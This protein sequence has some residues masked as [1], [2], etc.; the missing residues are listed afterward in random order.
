MWELSASE[1]S[2]EDDSHDNGDMIQDNAILSRQI[3]IN[4]LVVLLL[5][6]QPFS[7][8][9][10][11]SPHFS[12]FL[13]LSQPFSTFSNFLNVSLPS[14]PFSTFLHLSQ[15]FS[16]LLAQAYHTVGIGTGVHSDG[17]WCCPRDMLC[18]IQGPRRRPSA[19]HP[20]YRVVPR[21]QTKVDA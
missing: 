2:A 9:L 18:H 17:R 11:L 20:R 7:T 21:A 5:P 14:P 4:H 12:T 10:N 1:D 6:S 13:S 16:T 19:Q 15:P 8:F 3:L